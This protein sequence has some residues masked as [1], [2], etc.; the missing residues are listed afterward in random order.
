[1][2]YGKINFESELSKSRMLEIQRLTRIKALNVT[3]IAENMD[4]S[5]PCISPFIRHMREL[6]LIFVERQESHAFGNKPIN[7]Y[8]WV[9]ATESDEIPEPIIKRAPKP[10]ERDRLVSA[11]FGNFKGVEI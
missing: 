4:L 7:F 2:G 5:S 8:R 11:L 9:G 3:E 6:K 10:V 1:M